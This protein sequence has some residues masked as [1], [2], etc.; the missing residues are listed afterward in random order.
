MAQR[1]KLLA[2]VLA[3]AFPV[4]VFALHRL[5]PSHLGDTDRYYHLALSRMLADAHAFHL[6]TLPQAEDLGWGSYFPDK[7]FLFHVLTSIGY[8]FASDRGAEAA[9]LLVASGA[10]VILFW[11]A[12]AYLS[13][14]EAF[15]CAFAAFFTHSF[16][17]R[18]LLLRPHVL[19]IF[20]FL[21][22]NA[23]ILRRR[24]LL[25]A[26]ASAGYMLAYHAFYVPLFCLCL[27]AAL[28][29]F[30]SPQERRKL[31]RL[32]GFALVGWLVG[33]VVNP[34]FPSNVQM[35]ILHARLPFLAGG[36]L[37]GES[38]GSEL[39]PLAGPGLVKFYYFPFL[40]LL[41]TLAARR[42]EDFATRFLLVLGLVFGALSFQTVRAGEHFVPITGLL[43]PLLVASLPRRRA[44]AFAAAGLQAAVLAWISV[45]EASFVPDA[46][47]YDSIRRAV[48][49]IPPGE[50]KVYNCEWDTAPFLL[51][52]RPDLRFVDLLDP[53]FLYLAWPGAYQARKDLATGR[54]TDPRGLVHGL[55]HA[56][57]V[58]CRNPGLVAQLE[59]DPGFRRLYPSRA[60]GSAVALFRAETAPNPAF[61]RR[62]RFRVLSLEEAGQAQRY[63][64]SASE[65]LDAFDVPGFS[66]VLGLRDARRPAGA[67]CARVSAD[68]EEVK[69]LQGARFLG[70]GGGGAIR[71]WR[72]GRLVFASGPEYP[73]ARSV[74]AL[75]RL[76]PPLRAT[77]R[78]DA[79]VCSS[80]AAPFW[81]AALSLWSMEAARKVCGAKAEAEGGRSRPDS[82]ALF[83]TD[84]ESCLGTMA[85]PAVPLD[86]R[87]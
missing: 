1:R 44:L 21:L 62:L 19:A 26:L 16:V 37:R 43:L 27:A 35:G 40:I 5:T 22:L 12:L 47:L 67:S 42:L 65:K 11:F 50:A 54:I 61:V 78:I 10:A 66:V 2:V 14:F 70:L 53:S 72:N 71:A 39:Y 45:T 57:Y 55:F 56:D 31:H 59:A 86:L 83:S 18:M 60:G 76:D 15:A 87:P 33:I 9:S 49:A 84:Q 48:A 25:A 20:F 64:P 8:R 3:L 4:L 69:R 85:G 30:E 34:Y 13:P 52:A 68:P 23:A 6:E 58:L 7:E 75:A 29:C 46:P 73:R 81:T 41:G 28:A 32:C 24:P 79:L 36:A 82:A 74:Q 51:Y 17:F 80:A 77:D 38:F 63:L